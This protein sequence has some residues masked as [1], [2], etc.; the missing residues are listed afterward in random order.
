MKE[1]DNIYLSKIKYDC[2]KFIAKYIKD[3][4][5]S[6]TYKEIGM[7]QKFS[8]ARAGAIVSDL[9]EIGLMDRGKSS[10]RN[11]RMTPTQLN[12]VDKLAFNRE[13]KKKTNGS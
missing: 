7:H 6:P 11:I 3:N 10:H 5:F 12:K 4:K 13:Y 2:L 9:F 1:K 8:R